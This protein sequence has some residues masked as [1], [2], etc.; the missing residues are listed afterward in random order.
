MIHV[1]SWVWLFGSI[2]LVWYLWRLV[3][4]AVLGRYYGSSDVSPW[5]SGSVV[6]EIRRAWVRCVLPLL[7]NLLNHALSPEALGKLH[8]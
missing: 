5:L 6:S 7:R 1:W 8:V 4:Q 3:S 2:R